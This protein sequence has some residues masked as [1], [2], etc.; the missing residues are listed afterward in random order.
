VLSRYLKMS[1]LEKDDVRIELT[2]GVHPPTLQAGALTT[3]PIVQSGL[4]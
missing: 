3:R 2:A 4:Q 1:C